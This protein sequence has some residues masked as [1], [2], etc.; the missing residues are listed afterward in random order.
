[1]KSSH[2]LTIVELLIALAV[3]GIAFT[4]LALSQVNNLRASA[5][6]SLVSEVKAEAAS[7]LETQMASVLGVV[8]E[9]QAGW[10][11]AYQDDADELT[12]LGRSFFF[13][14]YYYSCPDVVVPI[15]G[16][17]TLRNTITC[18]GTI[19]SANG[20]IATTW[21]VAGENGILGEGALT[22]TVTSSHIQG[23]SIT[24]GD[25]VTCY[26]VYPSPTSSAPSPCP[27]P[28]DPASNTGGGR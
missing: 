21:T 27:E 24:M 15:T 26:D 5:R 17:T 19:N 9:G 16:R 14:D 18:T 23:P 13:Y 12:G 28:F 2:G 4:A 8:I 7:V 20:N 11:G 3:I 1:M 25:R 6:S 22:V 10:N